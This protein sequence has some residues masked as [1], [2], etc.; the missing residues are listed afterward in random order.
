MKA[1]IV[2][3]IILWILFA[4]AILNGNFVNA[5]ENEKWKHQTESIMRYGEKPIGPNERRIYTNAE[6]T[7]CRDLLFSQEQ[8]HYT[9]EF[10]CDAKMR[11][12]EGE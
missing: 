6:H 3:A 2:V 11:E 1:T 12:T 9:E 4:V 7:L 8:F 10:P 5:H